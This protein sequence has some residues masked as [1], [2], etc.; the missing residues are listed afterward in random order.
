MN[1][2]T[3]GLAPGFF[4]KGMAFTIIYPS[5]LQDPVVD[6]V[7]LH[8]RL[9]F[10]DTRKFLSLQRRY[11]HHEPKPNVPFKDSFIGF[12]HVVN[13]NFFDVGFNSML[14]TEVHHLLT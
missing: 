3:N 7:P 10:D 13:R 8:A 4:P 5:T 1:E 6:S 14:R 11:I 9:S 12:V 2:H